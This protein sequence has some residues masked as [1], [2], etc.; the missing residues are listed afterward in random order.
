MSDFNNIGSINR[1][2]LY[3]N[4]NEVVEI[5]S[6]I[7][8]QNVNDNTLQL[9]KISD[10][11]IVTDI[12]PNDLKFSNI[13]DSLTQ[14]KLTM[15]D[16]NCFVCCIFNDKNVLLKVGN[17]S[18]KLVLYKPDL[19]QDQIIQIKQYNENNQIK[20]TNTMLN[21]GSGFYVF[22]LTEYYT[23]LDFVEIIII[24]DNQNE[25]NKIISRIRSQTID[26][27]VQTTLQTI[28]YDWE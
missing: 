11:N 26:N 9:L 27:T 3:K 25:I 20:F 1:N 12:T 6:T 2:L 5:Y 24:D 8:Y 16:E 21:I 7:L 10:D 14:V 15:P 13:S 23:D 17:P 28:Y 18:L 4:R 19:N 22:D